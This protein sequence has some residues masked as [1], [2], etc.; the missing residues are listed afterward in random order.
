M[1]CNND[2]CSALFYFLCLFIVQRYATE[3]T[4][5]IY[6]LQIMDAFTLMWW[7]LWKLLNNPDVNSMITQLIIPIKT[8]AFHNKS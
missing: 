3:L 6:L 4:W 7:E 1:M 5:Q 2:R 8:I